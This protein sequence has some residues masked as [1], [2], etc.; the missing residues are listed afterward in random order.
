M[1]LMQVQPGTIDP[2]GENGGPI[3]DRRLHVDDVR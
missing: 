1:L 3:L 2:D